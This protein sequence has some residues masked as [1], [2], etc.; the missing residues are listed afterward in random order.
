[1]VALSRN[2]MTLVPLTS[3]VNRVRPVPDD[4]YSGVAEVFFAR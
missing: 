2:E 1:M 3:V 4:L